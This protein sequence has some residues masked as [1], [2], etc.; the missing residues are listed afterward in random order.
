M[1]SKIILSGKRACGKTTLFWDLQKLLNWPT[2][3]VSLFLRDYIHRFNL[4]DTEEVFSKSPEISRDIDTRVEQLLE[5]AHKVIIDTRLYGYIDRPFPDT[6]KV[7]LTA[8]NE[9]RIKRAAFRE[10]TT[11]EVQ[12]SRLIKKEE[13]WIHRMEVMYGRTDLFDPIHYDLV[14]DTSDLTPQQILV[15]LSEVLR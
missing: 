15:K 11:I 13:E 9:V 1:Y 8:R 2:F 6:L 14:V 10:Q 7:L 12:Q 3:S 4:R 5:S